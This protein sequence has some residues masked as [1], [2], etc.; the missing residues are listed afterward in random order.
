M[1]NEP[2]DF[3]A[4]VATRE[5]LERE[6]Q[7]ILAP[8]AMK[9]ADTLGRRVVEVADPFRTHFQRDRDRIIH[10][11]AFRR[12]IGKTQV[13]L[14]DTGDHYRTRL[15]HSIEVS[16]IARS[17][18]RSLRLN[19]DLT[20]A[21]ALAHDLGHAPFG[22]SGGDALDHLMADHGGFE[23]N[24]QSLR[25]VDYLEVKYA[26][27]RGLNLTYEVRESILKHKRPFEGPLYTDYRPDDSPLLEA[28]LVDLADGIAYNSH[29][30]DDGLRAG[31][32]ETEDLDRV[33]LWRRVK[34][35]VLRR[36]GALSGR[37][38]VQKAVAGVI[39]YLVK[40]L[41]RQ[42]AKNLAE[43]RIRSVEDV[44]RH[45]RPLV[46]FSRDVAAAEA[47]L[48][49][50][51]YKNFYTHHRV[52]GMRHRARVFLAAMFTAFVEH[53]ELL[54]TGFQRLADA[55]GI[56]RAVADYLAGMTDSYAQR[57]Y[58]RLFDPRSPEL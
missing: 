39:D 7:S 54:P 10:S 38:L 45:A 46:E 4:L 52:T 36:F 55:D 57:E 29:D 18:A 5:Q 17:I 40:D 42:T 30:I 6:E 22:H 32:L 16:Q 19:Q 27:F 11:T 23:H 44:R 20:E 8:F 3:D 9:S 56:H 25:I 49:A 34:D 15:T 1:A 14:S 2:S 21:V 58:R 43:A 47:E 31:I 53:R 28:Q 26:G 12:L 51:L 35:D 33:E 41:V 24:F 37:T 13:F 48:K 50:F